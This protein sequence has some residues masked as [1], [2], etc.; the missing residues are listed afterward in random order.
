MLSHILEE[1]DKPIVLVFDEIQEAARVADAEAAM[2]ALRAA[3][4]Q[5][6]HREGA[7]FSGSS[8]VLLL[9]ALSRA[10][11]PL[12]GFAQAQPYSLL[13]EDFVKHV[14]K[15]VREASSREFPQPFVTR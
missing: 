10:K 11:A 4:T 12:Y 7:V 13:K 3:F 9:Q 1:T 8:Q 15:K 14:S 2:A 6:S 5:A